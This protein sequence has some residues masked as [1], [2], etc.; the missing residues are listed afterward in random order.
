[1]EQT[2]PTAESHRSDLTPTGRPA[3]APASV[4]FLLSQ[5]GFATASG[6]RAALAPL[7]IEPQHWA[8]LRAVAANEGRSQRE[9]CGVLH[10]PPSRMVGLLDELEAKGLVERRLNAHD[11]RARAVHLTPEGRA[12]LDRALARAI[13]FEKW[14]ATPLDGPEREQLVALLQR[15]ADHYGLFRD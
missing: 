4:G 11:R 6:F 2:P 14:V 5:L 15:L 8:A 13:D 3:G 10:L 7:D 12:R 9:V 1:M